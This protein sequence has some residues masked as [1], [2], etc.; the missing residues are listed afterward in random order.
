MNKRFVCKYRKNKNHHLIEDVSIMP[1]KMPTK[2]HHQKCKSLIMTKDSYQKVTSVY[3]RITGK[4]PE[5]VQLQIA[6]GS[7]YQKED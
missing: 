4:P 5:D 1:A 2:H 7:Y 6:N 3:T